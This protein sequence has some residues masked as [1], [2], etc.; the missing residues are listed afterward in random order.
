[1]TY[2]LLIGGYTSDGLRVLTFDPEN[3]QEKLV[4]QESTINAGPDPSWIV[5]HPSNR[6]LIFITN[7]VEDG[8][9]TVVKLTGLDTSG[10]IRGE[11]TVDVSSGGQYPAHL[12]VLKD[13]VVVSNVGD[14]D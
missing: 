11:Q 6:S 14:R 3:E 2:N 8:K 12:L 1:M 4:A 7:E 10:E 9:V 5:Q 13:S